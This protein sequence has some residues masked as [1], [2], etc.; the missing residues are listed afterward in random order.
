MVQAAV[1]DG[2]VFDVSPFRQDGLALP[3]A[4]EKS[5]PEP[6]HKNKSISTPAKYSAPAVR[7]LLA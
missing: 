5:P 2:L 1:L 6:Q 3:L 7:S 4:A